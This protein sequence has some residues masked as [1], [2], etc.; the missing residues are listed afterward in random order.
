M[1]SRIEMG[2][3]KGK[4]D[5]PGCGA[6]V[7]WRF[8]DKGNRMILDRASDPNGNIVPKLDGTVHVLTKVEKEG[9]SPNVTRY[10]DHHV[11]CPYRDRWK[12][13]KS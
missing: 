11:T 13:G 9:L 10:T 12:K 5:I 3:C 4:G 2:T 6:E 1:S 8:N 7:M